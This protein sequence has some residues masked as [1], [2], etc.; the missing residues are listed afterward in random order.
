MMDKNV[1]NFQISPV[2]YRQHGHPKIPIKR[3]F[4]KNT[5]VATQ[6]QIITFCSTKNTMPILNFIFVV[7]ANF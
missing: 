4:L 5:P 3:I 1:Q 7:Y 6:D 2:A